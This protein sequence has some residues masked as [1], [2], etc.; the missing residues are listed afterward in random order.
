[1]TLT[2]NCEAH[3]CALELR[4]LYLSSLGHETDTGVQRFCTLLHPEVW[5]SVD[6]FQRQKSIHRIEYAANA[7][8]V[9]C[10]PVSAG[11]ASYCHHLLES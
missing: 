6:R 5:E 3:R 1:M 9:P 10:G 7:Y 2:I 4:E 8:N 11:L